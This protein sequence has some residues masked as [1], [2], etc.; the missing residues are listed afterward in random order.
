ML[1]NSLPFL[2]FFTV[3]FLAYWLLPAGLR[4]GLLLVASLFFY[5]MWIPQYVLL[6]L[7][8]LAVNYVL[9]LGIL[10]SSRPRLYLVTSIIVS[11]ATLGYFKY[12]GFAV[13]SFNVMRELTGAAPARVPDVLLPLGISF[14]TFQIIGLAVDAYR[15]RGV[16]AATFSEYVLF[17]SFFP[18]QIAGP[19]L[20]GWNL[21]PQF[22]S[23]TTLTA[24]RAHR[25]VWLICGGL[26][27]KVV[28]GDA[29]LAEYVDRVFGSPGYASGAE[30][31]L[32]IYSFAFQI[33]FDFSGYTDIARGLALLLGFE[34]PLN[35]REPYL[36]RNPSEF[37]RRWHITL[38]EWLRDYLY[39]PLGGNRTS[40][41]RAYANLL[42]TMVLG[43][44]W[45]GAGWNFL[46]WG[47]IHGMLLV[48]HRAVSHGHTTVVDKVH[49]R[50][51]PKIVLL[52]HAVCIAWVFFRAATFGDAVR[53]LETV[54]TGPYVGYSA[55]FQL[56][57]VTLSAALHP[58]E[59]YVRTHRTLLRQRLAPAPLAFAES[60]MIGA[61][62]GLVAVFAGFGGSFIYF[63]F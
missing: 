5:C 35:F 48:I 34:L 45:H 40:R 55:V 7:A 56:A 14:F 17:I 6:L 3:V 39:I 20:R 32:A 18:H 59:R 38:S 57:V 50:D 53:I 15:N 47:A 28:F 10:R 16:V 51:V 4:Q 43:G 1:F 63:Q 31:L 12:A 60:V 52:F 49:L 62:L 26:I 58:V 46:I 19:I 61:M 25:A 54:I 24:E 9:L 23:A 2:L 11:L 33:Y 37:W 13:E 8:I 36:S 41:G 27:K 44:I 22:R 42:M 30:H 29:L 21:L